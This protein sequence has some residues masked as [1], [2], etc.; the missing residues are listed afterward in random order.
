MAVH[1]HGT[2]Q[3][4]GLACSESLIGECLIKEGGETIDGLRAERDGL[5]AKIERVRA[6]AQDGL[7][8]SDYDFGLS[9]FWVLDTL[10]T[11]PAQSLANLQAALV[12]EYIDSPE[13]AESLRG[14]KHEAW[15]QGRRT[16]SSRAM[17]MMSDEPGLSLEVANP[18]RKT[19]ESETNHE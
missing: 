18:Y 4:K 19:T 13:H 15:D 10:S 7:E 3:G 8:N 5:L 1:N 14:A 2:E 17:R 12:L 16:G 9:S 6:S 11:S